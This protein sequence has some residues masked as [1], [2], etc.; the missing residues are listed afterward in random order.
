MCQ[1][2]ISKLHWQFKSKFYGL[3]IRWQFVSRNGIKMPFLGVVDFKSSTLTANSVLNGLSKPKNIF[4]FACPLWTKSSIMISP[5]FWPKVT[6]HGVKSNVLKRIFAEVI[7]SLTQFCHHVE[8]LWRRP[9]IFMKA[10]QRF[11]CVQSVGQLFQKIHHKQPKLELPYKSSILKKP[12]HITVI[13]ILISI[14]FFKSFWHLCLPPCVLQRGRHHHISE[15]RNIWSKI[16]MTLTT[17]PFFGW[18]FGCLEAEQ[19]PV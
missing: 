14:F 7:N 1:S 15:R 3:V 9:K 16:L 19:K 10:I 5:S 6:S 8:K 17:I 12:R 13:K 18:R 2:K 4:N 11:W